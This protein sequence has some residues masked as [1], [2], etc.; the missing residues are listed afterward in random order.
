MKINR[1]FL[2][3]LL[4]GVML[5]RSCTKD[6][7]QMLVKT[8]TVTNILTTTAYISGDIL[9]LGEGVSQYG[10]CWSTTPNASTY[11]IKTT[12]GIPTGIGGFTS[13]MTGLLPGTV[14]FVKAYCSRGET[15]VYGSEINFTTATADLPQL[16]TTEIT[17]ITKTA[18]VTGGNITSQGGTPVTSRGVCWSTAANPIADA[19]KTT[20]GTGTGNFVSNITD[21]S[22]GTT[23]Y[24]RA[25]ATNDGGTNYGNE[26][27]FT[28]L[29][30]AS[31]PPT[32]TTSDVTSL[33]TNSALCGGEVTDEGS[34]SVTARGVCWGKDP[35]P[36]ITN[37]TTNDGTG[38][39]S[40]TSSL[41][42]LSPGTK[43]Y[44][45]AYATSSAG[46][47]YGNEH[48]F[49]TGAVLAEL[50]TVE[51]NTI[52]TTTAKSGGN[53]TSDG[54]SSVTA[55]GV[56][57]S[58]SP[59][60]TLSDSHTVD[61]FGTGTFISSLTALES[62]TKYYVCAYATNSIGTAYGNV[63]SFPTLAQLTTTAV[64][65]IGITTAT[66][67]G[68]VASGG[69]AD[70]TERGV[71][72]SINPNPTIL[73]N[74]C[75]DGGGTGGFSCSLSN[76]TSNTKYYV[77]AYATNDGGTNY[78]NQVEFV[79]L[80]S[81]GS[82]I[83]YSVYS[84]GAVIGSTIEE[85]GGEAITARGVCWSY[86]NPT[87]ADDKTEDN[88]GS[89]SFI[90]HIT[91]LPHSFSVTI[92]M[93][94]RTYATNISGT[95]Y[96]SLQ[97]FTTTKDVFGVDA[98]YYTTV[99]LGEQLWFRENLKTSKY[100]NGDLIPTTTAII[101]DEPNPKYQW[102]YN[103]LAQNLNDYGR[104]YTWPAITDPR[105]VCPTGWHVPTDDDWSE[106]EVYLQN[107][108]F[109]YNGIIDSDTYR[110]TNNYTAKA[111]S[112]LTL[113]SASSVAGAPGNTDF[114]YY[115]NRSG[116]IALP[117]GRRTSTGGFWD[118]GS[119]GYWWSST[120]N[121]VVATSRSISSSNATF[122]RTTSSQSN[123]GYAVRCIKD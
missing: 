40:F 73:N 81:V 24:V 118:L 61:D 51:I 67:G 104:L 19:N 16:S 36:T 46:T 115:R 38:P 59:T 99:Q 29:S 6:E 58:S 54:G 65:G 111:L 89:G 56:C 28:T 9:D 116:F 33:T 101:E 62:N 60:P 44:V 122:I 43:Y 55:R 102:V 11:D 34:E 39:G 2:L 70:I 96:G 112:S 120:G 22:A 17:G 77:R 64:S 79:T 30:E 37:S 83:I 119:S 105:G 90:S 75:Q 12:L 5:C 84:D 47:S 76:L 82:N 49:T 27:S 106:L 57:W 41:T 108:D 87:I 18:A 69:G 8:G 98:Y 31:V 110:S 103:D 92:T 13:E 117:G 25:Y 63:L 78:G 123:Y 35:N 113:W 85:G 21:L 97:E 14:Y 1:L 10:H 15:I 109:N 71:C 86:T 26:L 93:R 45:R 94:Y 72:W 66:G 42:G 20:N 7:R 80:P 74:T 95:S 23:Y 48:N 91:G 52:T 32:V 50:T 68:S 3:L 88:T 4:P 100:A 107:N 53:I 121:S 114:P